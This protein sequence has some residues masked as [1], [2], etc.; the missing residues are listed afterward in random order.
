MRFALVGGNRSE[1][2][3]KARGSCPSCGAETVAK[4]G[5]HVIWHWAH[6]SLAHCDKWW[7]AETEWHRQWKSHF[8]QEWQEVVLLDQSTGE[9]HVADV[10]TASGLVIEFQRSTINPDEVQAREAFYRRMIWI[11]DGCR[12]DADKYNFSNMRSRP[13]GDGIANFTWYG[14]SKLFARWHTTKP[15]F[16]DFGDRGFWRILRYEPTTKSGLAGLV[17]VAAFVELATSGTTDF[18]SVGGPA[19]R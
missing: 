13:D 1:P 19:S 8:P 7:E 2:Q 15:V 17:N 12:N 9:Q 6:K 18:S 14:R 16:I 5:N 10:R 4:C 3:P 11:V